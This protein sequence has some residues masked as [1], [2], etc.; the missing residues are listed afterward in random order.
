M[1]EAMNLTFRSP[2]PTQV[3]FQIGDHVIVA[4]AII[5]DDAEYLPGLCELLG[6]KEP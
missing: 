6:G 4:T 1:R 2:E 5:A 3:E